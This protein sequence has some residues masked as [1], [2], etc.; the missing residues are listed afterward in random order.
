M[1]RNIKIKLDLAETMSGDA[2]AIP[3]TS[4]RHQQVEEVTMKK[5]LSA[6]PQPKDG[7]AGTSLLFDLPDLPEW[8]FREST[9]WR[10]DYLKTIAGH[11]A[12][13]PVARKASTADSASS[14]FRASQATFALTW[15]T[16]KGRDVCHL[17]GSEIMEV[18]SGK[19]KALMTLDV[20]RGS[21]SILE[22]LSLGFR[23]WVLPPG[24]GC[25]PDSQKYGGTVQANLGEL[26]KVNGIWMDT[27]SARGKATMAES[28]KVIADYQKARMTKL[29]AFEQ[30]GFIREV[31]VGKKSVSRMKKE[32]GK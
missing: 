27:K 11:R 16:P 23:I 3:R 20:K 14:S 21:H 19:K 31:T 26:K 9:P 29:P 24:H 18:V 1:T 32:L 4:L 2:L 12:P 13:L 5:A 8:D 15:Q 30:R 6:L 17:G 25:V 10:A 28:K 22:K 7:E